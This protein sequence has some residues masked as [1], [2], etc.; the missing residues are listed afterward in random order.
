MV[1]ATTSIAA[2]VLAAGAGS[3][4]GYKPKC[5]LQRDGEPLLARQLRLLGEV[6]VARAVVVLGHHAARIEPLLRR[7]PPRPGLSWVINPAPDEGP[8]SSLRCGLAALPPDLDGVLV[9]LGDLP[10]LQA[11]DFAAVLQA[12]RRR[13]PGIELVLPQHAGQPGHPLIFGHELRQWLARQPVAL[14]V[15]DWRRAHPAQVQALAVDH[16][17]GSTDID[18]E[19]DLPVLARDFGVTLRWPDTP[20]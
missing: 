9:V 1:E 14:G 16:P 15:R 4:F 8:A 11:E 17:R 13:E 18:R 5:L 19:A 12:W 20:Y 2:I 7:L 6:G 3:R 10:L